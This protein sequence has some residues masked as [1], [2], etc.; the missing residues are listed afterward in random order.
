MDRKKFEKLVRE[1]ITALPA[2]TT[3]AMDNVA[4]VVEDRARRKKAGERGIRRD[5]VLIGLYEGIAKTERDSGYFGILPDKITIFQEAIEELSDKNEEKLKEL[6]NETV[7]HE[8]GH[9]LGFDEKK[10][11]ALEARRNKKR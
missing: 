3:K 9:H 7:W 8:V 5:E 4:F 1:A 6:V 2:K 11:S 10:I